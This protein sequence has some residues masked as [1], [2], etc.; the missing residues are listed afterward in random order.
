M[1]T[2]ALYKKLAE[3]NDI[4]SESRD[5][6]TD[7][8]ITVSTGALA[9]SITF[10]KALIGSDAEHI[11]LLKGAWIA[12][13]I[14]AVCG[15]F[16]HLGGASAAIRMVKAMKVDPNRAYA[17]THPIYRLLYLAVVLAFPSGLIM[18]MLFAVYNTN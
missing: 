14:S 13:A 2:E 12:L 1:N 7:R 9:F 16:L 17:G 11:W 15:V 8:L 4:K 18:F 10:R 3:M 6:F 5:K